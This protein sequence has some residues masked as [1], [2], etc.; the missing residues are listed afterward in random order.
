MGAGRYAR[1]GEAKFIES[2]IQR[3]IVNQIGYQN[4][5]A[6][7]KSSGEMAVPILLDYL[8]SSAGRQT[9][10]A[11]GYDLHKIDK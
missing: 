7:L 8:R 4:G 3:L 10:Q 11:Y 5:I 1:R 9:I 6:N 2:N